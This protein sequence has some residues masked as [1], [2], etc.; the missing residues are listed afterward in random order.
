MHG[1]TAE[2]RYNNVAW[3]LDWDL[4]HYNRHSGQQL[5]YFQS[6]FRR[7]I[8]VAL[9]HLEFLGFVWDI[10]YSI[11]APDILC[12]F[13]ALVPSDALSVIN[14]LTVKQ[15]RYAAGRVDIIPVQCLFL[16]K[17]NLKPIQNSKIQLNICICVLFSALIPLTS[18]PSIVLKK[19]TC[20]FKIH[21]ARFE[22]YSGSCLAS[23][24]S[25][26]QES[27]SLFEA[28]LLFFTKILSIYLFQELLLLILMY[29]MGK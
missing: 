8:C 4:G 15:W 23:H 14:V 18:S 28:W 7:L 27:L 1:T 16:G 17:Q 20:M 26:E 12:I 29:Q 25:V 11:F 6:P 9:R 10:S 21:S 3:I 24:S 5:Q 2:N 13:Y 19:C 22:M